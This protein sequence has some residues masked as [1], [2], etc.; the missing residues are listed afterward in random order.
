[1]KKTI[2]DILLGL[3]VLSFVIAMVSLLWISAGNPPAIWTTLGQV[4][5]VLFLVCFFLLQF[6]IE[7]KKGK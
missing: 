6:F 3:Y 1:M 4:F 7:N 2:K 5:M